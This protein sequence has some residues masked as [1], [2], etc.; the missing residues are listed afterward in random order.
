MSSLLQLRKFP[1]VIVGIVFLLGV[2]VV[3]LLAFLA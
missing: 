3:G 1:D 2:I